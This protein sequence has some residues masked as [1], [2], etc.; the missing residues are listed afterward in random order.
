VKEVHRLGDV[1]G[2][3]VMRHPET[4]RTLSHIG[5]RHIT[6]IIFSKLARLARST[7]ELLQVAEIFRPEDA[8]GFHAI[9][10]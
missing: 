8:V 3:S 4:P 6:A 7:R 5:A 1:S 10:G 9:A 2:K